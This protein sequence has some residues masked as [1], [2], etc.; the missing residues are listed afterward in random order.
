MGAP[1]TEKLTVYEPAA[2]SRAAPTIVVIDN[3]DSFTFNLVQ[4]LA[5]LGARC[6][7]F[8]NDT[9]SI[10]RIA[11]LAPDGLLLSPGHGEPESAG[12]TLSAIAA[13]HTEI[14]ILGVC[15]GHQAI[16]R[17]FGAKI[18]P[19]RRLLHGKACRVEHDGSGIFE[20]LPNP[21]TLARYNS[22]VVDS[23]TLPACLRVTA[24]SE[25]EI[26]AIEHREHHVYGVQFHPESVLSELGSE[27][28]QNWLR[29]L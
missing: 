22:L 11:E 7:V 20:A 27:L 25:D 29:R 15:L 19:A 3:Y 10:S 8:E 18:V 4:S 2:I 12:I 14:P 21:L 9:V 17:A 28:L 13:L 1:V 23:S 16:A 24:T 6:L 5:T 26:M